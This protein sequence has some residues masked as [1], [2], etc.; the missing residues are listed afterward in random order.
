MSPSIYE[1]SVRETTRL[2]S[3]IG[4]G[5][6]QSVT[7]RKKASSDKRVCFYC[8][9][10]SHLISDCKVWKEKN[11]ASKSKS[12]A[13]IHPAYEESYTIDL[14]YQPFLLSGSVS[15]SV[16]S[17]CKP[18][19]ILR[20]TGSVQSFILEELLPR[21]AE[22]YSGTDVLICGIGMQ[23]INVPLHNVYLKSDLVTGTVKLGVRSQLPVEGVGVIL[24]NDLAGG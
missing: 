8:L 22:T 18:V 1:V 6:T 2:F 16:D 20:D 9:D 3:C 13:L 17:E 10:P 23:C 24:G 5:E 4:K 12:V 11:S 15:V 21:S 19:T 7:S 14:S